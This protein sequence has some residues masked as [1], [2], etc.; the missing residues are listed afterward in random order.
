MNALWSVE[1]EVLEEGRE[2]TRR[3]L[4]ARL[5]AEADT[6]AAECPKSGQALRDVRRR[7]LSLRTAVG[8]VSLKVPYGRSAP[9]TLGFIRF[10]WLGDWIPASAS[11]RS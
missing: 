5:Q 10:G 3:R 4:E 8:E 6:V 2:W 1:Q 9:V 7:R 11:A